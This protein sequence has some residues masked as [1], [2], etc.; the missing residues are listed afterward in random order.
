[1]FVLELLFF[2]PNLLNFHVTFNRSL[3]STG[4]KTYR[5]KSRLHGLWRVGERVYGDL[6]RRRKGDENEENRD[7]EGGKKGKRTGRKGKEKE[8]KRGK[9]ECWKIR[10]T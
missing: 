7:L 3:R 10:E 2:S 5:T 9:R 4:A 1:M 6:R 8:E